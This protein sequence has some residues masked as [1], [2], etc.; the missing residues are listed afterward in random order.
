MDTGKM[1]YLGGEQQREKGNLS[2][3]MTL[4]MEGSLFY[5][6]VLIIHVFFSWGNV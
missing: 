1:S 6:Q 2:M 3:G 4:R 5:Y